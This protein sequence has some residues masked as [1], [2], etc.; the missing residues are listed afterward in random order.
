MKKYAANILTGLRIVLCVPMLLFP[1]FSPGFLVLYLLCGLTDMIDGTVARK[2]HST[3][4]FGAKLDTVAD[5]LFMAAAMVKLLPAISVPK[6]LWGWVG[7]IAAI[8]V[9]NILAGLLKKKQLVAEHTILNKITGSLL[10]V[11]PLTL[12]WI[13]LQY[14]GAVVCF[15]ATVAAVQEGSCIIKG[16]EG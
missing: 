10:F 6:W 9:S 16:K 11:L 5:L 13:Q 1:A 8:K 12:K 4:S 15:V 3:S 14:S 2:T 7:G